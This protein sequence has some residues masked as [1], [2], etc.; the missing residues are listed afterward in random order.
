VGSTLV[1]SL[2][3]MCLFA[4]AATSTSDL[5]VTHVRAQGSNLNKTTSIALAERELE[6]LRALDYASIASRSSTQTVGGLR[7]TL[8]TT[9]TADVPAAGMKTINA[10]VSW[11]DLKGAQTYAINAIYAAV[12]R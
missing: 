11:I 2:I 7:Y 1:E 8:T 4:L 6:D 12:K 3:A 5:L 9:V 10:V